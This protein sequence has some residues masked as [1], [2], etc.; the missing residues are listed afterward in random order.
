MLCCANT[1]LLNDNRYKYLVQYVG[2]GDFLHQPLGHA[3]VRLRGIKRSTGW[4]PHNLCPQGPQ[5]VH[6]CQKS[7]QY[8][9]YT[10]L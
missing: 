8:L 4:G 9:I 3:Y 5:N 1:Q 7:A 2:I 10:F 6:L